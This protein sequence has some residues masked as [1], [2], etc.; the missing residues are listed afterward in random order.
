MRK[1]RRARRRIFRADGQSE[2]RSNGGRDV[3]GIPQ[4]TEIDKEDSPAE[5]LGPAM[6]DGDGDRGL[7][8]AARADDGHEAIERKSVRDLLDDIFPADHPG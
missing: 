6:P 3:T 7:A 8:D 2:R 5:I 1:V 4:R